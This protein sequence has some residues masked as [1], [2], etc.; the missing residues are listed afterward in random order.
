VGCELAAGMEEWD[1]RRRYTCVCM[2]V[3]VCV[4]VP[5]GGA[6]FSARAQG[7]GHQRRPQGPRHQAGERSRALV[8]NCRERS[9][10]LSG[11]RP[12][13]AAKREVRSAACLATGIG[14]VTEW[15]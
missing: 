5:A 9:S 6:P 14:H 13:I 8:P 15:P 7:D 3:C 1:I 10:F 4:C 12:L 11:F 2:S